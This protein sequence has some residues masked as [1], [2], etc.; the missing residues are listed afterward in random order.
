MKRATI[1]IT[2]MVIATAGSAGNDLQAQQASVG[3]APSFQNVAERA[4]LMA[5]RRLEGVEYLVK[6]IESPMM[7]GPTPPGAGPCAM[8][9]CIAFKNENGVMRI[10]TPTEVQVIAGLAPDA[11]EMR[12]LGTA[13]IGAQS[14]FN[15]GIK[16]ELMTA[17]PE[18]GLLVQGLAGGNLGGEAIDPWVNPFEMMGFGGGFVLAGASALDT[19][20]DDIASGPEV[21]RAQEE[22]RKQ[23]IK[24]A[25]HAGVVPFN[26]G[27]AHEF[28]VDNINQTVE[29]EG[30]G[31][32]TMG[33]AR[34]WF[35]ADELVMLK[36]RI[37][38]VARQGGTDK[39][40]YIET[41]SRDYRHVPGSNLY[42]PYE[43]V[44]RMG[45]MLSEED[46]AQMA[47]AKAQ[48]DEFEAQL[49]S[50]PP[51]QRAMMERMMGGQMETMRGLVN[52]GAF[53]STQKVIEIYVNPDLAQLYAANP[54]AIAAATGTQQTSGGN[55]VAR[56][57]ADLLALGYDP[58]VVN[59]ELTTPTVIAISQFQTEKGL[60]V[61]GEATEALAAAL[62][63]E[64]SR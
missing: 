50:M 12:M 44:T 30:G 64:L 35:D 28:V 56:I 54:A 62:A 61:T 24:N 60:D 8:G 41:E 18:L 59:G 3:T 49:A 29:V 1:A 21:A 16:S 13:M 48:L 58:G 7:L 27:S 22:A 2:V 47:E 39:P 37:D 5:A 46:M 11:A 55:L 57:Q 25:R 4:S 34:M 10:L 23:L 31:K 20:T 14:E 9:G 17:S 26:G 42:E 40:F 51:D 43:S 6:K 63:T 32:F 52:S 19:A 15:R 45:G 53:E 36:H 38:G 33:A